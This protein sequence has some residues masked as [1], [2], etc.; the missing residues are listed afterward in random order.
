MATKFDPATGDGDC[1][2]EFVE[3]AYPTRDPG[4]GERD[5][6]RQTP[7]ARMLTRR[8]DD[9]SRLSAIG[10]VAVDGHC[11]ERKR[12]RLDDPALTRP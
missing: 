11:R 4:S 9:H 6:R 10:R 7:A 12:C 8:P 1:D 2:R 3:R 5:G